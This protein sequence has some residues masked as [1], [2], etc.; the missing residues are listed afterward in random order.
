MYKSIDD[1]KTDIFLSEIPRWITHY[2]FLLTI[3]LLSLLI[4]TATFVK[5]PTTIL[6]KVTITSKTVTTKIDFNSYQKLKSSQTISIF[7]PFSS[8]KGIISKSEAYAI[9]NEIHLPIILPDSVIQRL[10]FKDNLTC[11]GE[12]IIENK[13]I[14]EK[15]LR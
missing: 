14:L 11:D 10:P 13:S 4:G 2:G 1:N 6:L 7:S 8:I 5:Y 3:M 12:I 9:G 15:I